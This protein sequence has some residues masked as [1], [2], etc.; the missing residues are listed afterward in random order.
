MND[1]FGKGD[2]AAF[3]SANDFL[4][5]FISHYVDKSEHAISAPKRDK[6]STPASQARAVKDREALTKG[7]EYVKKLFSGEVFGQRY[8]DYQQIQ[9]DS[10]D[11]E[12]QG[13]CTEDDII[14]HI[15]GD[16][17]NFARMVEEYGDEFEV[18]NLVVKYNPDEDIHYFYYKK[19]GVAEVK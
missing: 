15:F 8:K 11:L 12:Y 19:Q 6:A 1:M 13:N 17:N 5:Q 3:S 10:D 7:L 18:D 16:V 2:L 4:Y 9:E 14:E